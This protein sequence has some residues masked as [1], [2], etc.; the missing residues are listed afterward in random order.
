M[1]GAVPTWIPVA[2]RPT[3]C[4]LKQD[5]FKPLPAKVHV[6]RRKGQHLCLVGSHGAANDK[7]HG[8]V[9]ETSQQAAL[10]IEGGGQ[11]IAKRLDRMAE[12]LEGSHLAG[13]LPVSQPP[14]LADHI[15]PAPDLHPSRRLPAD[16][17]LA[18]QGGLVN[19][20]RRR[21]GE[22]LVLHPAKRV[23]RSLRQTDGIWALG[24]QPFLGFL[25]C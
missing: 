17:D 11:S 21:I 20:H 12:G 19:L 23:R 8:R 3:L 22:E 25:F 18:V 14:A 1:H 7:V 6:R 16:G 24:S 10:L 13:G 15:G 2:G 9:C 5:L 4:N